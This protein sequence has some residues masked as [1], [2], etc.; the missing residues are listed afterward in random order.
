MIKLT[1][2][3]EEDKNSN[4]KKEKTENITEKESEEPKELLEEEFEES[5]DKSKSPDIE[6]VEADDFS[7]NYITGVLGGLN[8]AGGRIE[9]YQ[10]RVIP[11]VNKENKSKMQIKKIK[12]ELKTEIHLSPM[13][14][15][16]VTKWMIKQLKQ[17]EDKH[18]KIKPGSGKEDNENNQENKEV[19]E[20]ED[21][22]P[23]TIYR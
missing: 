1:N 5:E 9:F 15:K 23:G 3:E 20:I 10:D 12:R 8:P 7:V 6:L 11:E 4:S 21:E 17:Y 18:G 16:N 13:E 22:G 2:N 14:F 19:Q